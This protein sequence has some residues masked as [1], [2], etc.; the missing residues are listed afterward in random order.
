MGKREKKA[1]GGKVFLAVA[2]ARGKSGA[3]KFR[4]NAASLS[5]LSRVNNL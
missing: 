4:G 5:K 3:R 2:G 1:G